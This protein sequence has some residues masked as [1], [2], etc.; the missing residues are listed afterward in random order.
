MPAFT[1]RDSLNCVVTRKLL[2]LSMR[3]SRLQRQIHRSRIPTIAVN[4]KIDALR[5]LHR[6]DE[7]LALS[8]EAMKHLPNASSKGHELQILITRAEFGKI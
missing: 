3:Q 7:A 6:Y 8:A 1:A 4:A 5:G 2:L